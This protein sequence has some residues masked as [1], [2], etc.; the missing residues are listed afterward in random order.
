MFCAWKLYSRKMPS[1]SKTLEARCSS[2]EYSSRE[3]KS[4]FSMREVF[5]EMKVCR[6][7]MPSSSMV[8]KWW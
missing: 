2:R 3:A 5:S 6:V 7:A 8:L 4:M 1:R